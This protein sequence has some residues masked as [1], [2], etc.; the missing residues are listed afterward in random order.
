MLQK[1]RLPTQSEMNS[2]QA[3]FVYINSYKLMIK[4]HHLT[5]K[6]NQY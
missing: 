1:Q 3:D 4:L 5:S 2:A 6:I